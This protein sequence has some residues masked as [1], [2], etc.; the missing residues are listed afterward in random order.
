MK[1]PRREGAER[2]A[3]LGSVPAPALWLGFGGVV[4]FVVGAAAVLILSAPFAGYALRVLMTYAAIILSFVGAVHWGLAIADSAGATSWWRL[5]W[6][7]VP[8]LIGWVAVLVSPTVGLPMLIIAF[9][10][11]AAVDHAAARRKVAPAWYPRLR[12]PLTAIVIICLATA[13]LR[14]ILA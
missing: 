8:A 4:P 3:I 6:S 10:T 9:A 14:L 11:A 7:V 1:R 12:A 13:L 5:G 2:A